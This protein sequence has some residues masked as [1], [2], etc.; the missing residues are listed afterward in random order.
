VI[1]LTAYQPDDDSNDLSSDLVQ[2]QQLLIQL[3]QMSQSSQQKLARRQDAQ[4]ETIEELKEAVA[5]TEAEL[6]KQQ[7]AYSLITVNML[8][9]MLSAGWSEKEKNAIGIKLGNF[10][11]SC[12]VKPTKVPHPSL[13]NGV[14]GYQPSIVKTW[15]EENAYIVP[16]ELRYVD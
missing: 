5:K 11:R 6:R 14:N 4:A 13:P 15:L 10:S 8:D 9:T 7:N 3:M 12:F 16:S 2:Q 1:N